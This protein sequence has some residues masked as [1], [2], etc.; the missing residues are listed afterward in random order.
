MYLDRETIHQ[1]GEFN[2]FVVET[3][4]Q[5]GEFFLRG[6]DDPA[7]GRSFAILDEVPT[8]LAEFLDGGSEIFDLVAAT[9]IVLSHFVDDE[10][11]CFAGQTT[12]CEFKDPF[13]NGL[14]RHGAFTT[15]LSVRP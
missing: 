14:D 4:N 12:T 8:D 13:N 6:D 9:G 7:W 15:P 3:A 1:P 10:D 11:D 2:P 5:L